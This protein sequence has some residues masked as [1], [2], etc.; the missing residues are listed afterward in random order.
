[1]KMKA[2]SR[3]RKIIIFLVLAAMALTALI[4]I[5]GRSSRGPDS[6]VKESRPSKGDIRITVSTTGTIYPRN[7]LEIKPSV[8]G[9]IEKML[10]AEGDYVKTGQILA[11]MSSTDRAALIDAARLQGGDSLKYWQEAYKPIPIVAPLSGTVIVRSVEPGQTVTTSSVIVVISDRLIVKAQVDETDISRVSVG[12]SADTTLDS[13]PEIVTH[14]KVTH[15]YYESTTSNNVTIYYVE[16]TPDSIPAEF[17]SGMSATIEIIR[18][19]RKNVLMIPKDSVIA[20]GQRS[21][22]MLKPLKGDMPEKR[23][24]KTGLSNDG[25]FEVISGITAD[26]VILEFTQKPAAQGSDGK[27]NPFMPQPPR[28]KSL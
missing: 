11:V 7:R 12:Q 28:R 27:R 18:K 19:E 17:R 4:L 13:H 22:V 9:R 16:I 2:K 8:A 1:M 25:S 21:Y 15:I 26:D 10:V 14:G 3:G 24:I 6:S 5:K 20:E 23:E